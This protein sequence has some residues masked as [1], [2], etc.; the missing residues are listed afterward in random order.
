[1]GV[2]VYT[3]FVTC[4]IKNYEK[5]QHKLYDEKNVNMKEK[6]VPLQITQQLC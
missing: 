6:L 3:V 5:E 1:M 2:T 4:S